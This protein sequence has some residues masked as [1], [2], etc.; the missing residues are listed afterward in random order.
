MIRTWEP[1]TLA[2]GQG[3]RNETPFESLFKPSPAVLDHSTGWHVLKLLLALLDQRFSWQI[4]TPL[5]AEQSTGWQILKPLLGVLDQST[6][7]Q[8]LKPL[9]GV[10]DQSTGWQI[11][12]PLPEF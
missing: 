11:L 12:K 6:G 5:L 8:I 7:W 9:L 10:L 3:S 2:Q 4:L 1:S